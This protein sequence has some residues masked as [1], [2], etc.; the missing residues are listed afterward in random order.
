MADMGL[1]V[2]GGVALDMTDVFS[3]EHLGAQKDSFNPHIKSHDCRL[4]L[5]HLVKDNA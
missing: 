1:P 2:T 4:F 3:G 5:C